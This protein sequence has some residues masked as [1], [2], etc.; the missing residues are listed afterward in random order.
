M[1]IAGTRT[2]A[3]LIILG[4]KVVVKGAVQSEEAEKGKEKE[5][6]AVKEKDAE[7]AKER[8]RS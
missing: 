1:V 8:E 2:G 4:P 6:T 5:R 3:S 7:E